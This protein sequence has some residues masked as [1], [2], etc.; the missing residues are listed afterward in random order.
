MLFVILMTWGAIGYALVNNDILEKT[1]K[2][3]NNVVV[4]NYLPR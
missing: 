1:K 3:F 4:S 2:S